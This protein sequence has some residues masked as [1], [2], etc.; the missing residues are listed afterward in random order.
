M[1]EDIIEINCIK[2]VDSDSATANLYVYRELDYSETET[3]VIIEFDYQPEE[4][5]THDYPGCPAEVTI[6]KIK[7]A[8]TGRIEYNLDE[9]GNLDFAEEEIAERSL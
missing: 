5:Q 9:I 6:T 3:D 8:E 4:K 2:V 1:R 7:D